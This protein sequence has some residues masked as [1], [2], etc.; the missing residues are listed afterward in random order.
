MRSRLSG[1]NAAETTQ[2]QYCRISC[3]FRGRFHDRSARGGPETAAG[4]IGHGDECVGAVAAVGVI[5]LASLTKSGRWQ[6]CA[7]EIHSGSASINAGVAVK[8]LRDCFLATPIRVATLPTK[9]SS[10]P[11]Y[12]VSALSGPPATAATDAPDNGNR[13]QGRPSGIHYAD[14]QGDRVEARSDLRVYQPWCRR[15]TATW[16][17]EAAHHREPPLVG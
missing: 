7:R 10:T 15:K 11:C 6:R 2:T 12:A 1:R 14:A 9:N 13:A 16:K 8:A 4:E 3:G 17:I 5:V